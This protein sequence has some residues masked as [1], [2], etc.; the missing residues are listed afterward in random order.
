VLPIGGLKEKLLAAHRGGIST[1]IIPKENRRDLREVPRRVL[2]T[3]RVVLVDH[4][5]EVLREALVVADPDAVF[6]P[7]RPLMEYRG[8]ELVV[9]GVPPAP[10]SESERPPPDSSPEERPGA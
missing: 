10:S 4:V 6:G 1:V 7:P 3:T 8:G 2:K 9:N 5:D